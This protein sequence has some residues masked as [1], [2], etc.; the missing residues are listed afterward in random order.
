MHA[1]VA[2]VR[3][4]NIYVTDLAT[5][6]ETACHADGGENVINGT[7]DLGVRRGAEPARRVS[8]EPDGRRIAFLATGPDGDRPFSLLNQDR[9]TRLVPVRYPRPGTPN[10]EVK[11][12][13]VEISTGRT[14]WIEAR[15]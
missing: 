10:S 6:D 9:S 14:T 13:V 1:R 12:G 3:D 2:F 8:L 15:L 4:N 7:S 11:I 5:G